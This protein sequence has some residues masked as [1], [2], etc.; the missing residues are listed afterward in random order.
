MAQQPPD[1]LNRIFLD[2]KSKC[3]VPM[4]GFLFHC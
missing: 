1:L 2:L 4:G 3:V